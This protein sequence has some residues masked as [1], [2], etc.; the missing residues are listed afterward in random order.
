MNK[1]QNI[2]ALFSQPALQI[3]LIVALLLITGCL[4][5]YLKYSRSQSL[6]STS[7]QPLEKKEI[8]SSTLSDVEEIRTLDQKAWLQRLRG[9]LEKTRNALLDNLQSLFRG[10]G[11]I[12]EE[13]LSKLHETLY[14][15]DI[16]VRTVDRLTDHLKK[17]LKDQ[18]QQ[19]SSWEPI[20]KILSEEMVQILDLPYETET[21][22]PHVI[23]VIG[24][25]GVGKTTTI[26]KLAAHYLAE[27]K[28]VLLCAA[29]TYR[30]AAIDQLEIW[31]KRLGV[32]VIA[33]QEGSDPAAVAY[34][35]VKAAVARDVDVLLIDT[36]G[37]LHNKRHLMDELAK[38]TKVM[39]REIPEAP[40]E[41]YLVL[42]ATTG[43]NAMMQLRSFQEITKITGICLT[44]LDGT[45]KGGVILGLADEYKIP[46][47]YVGVGEKASD[48]RKFQARDFV[49][50]LLS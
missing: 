21:K 33:H 41:T 42:D 49:E 36:A 22:K 9:G 31:G 25:N 10:Q 24:V 20:K 14:R 34:D 11:P 43:Q 46:I 44:K 40:H 5:Y 35:S 27:N 1:E 32:K 47:K 39:K 12:N 19:E 45:A 7:T 30:A 26:G 28:S 6:H 15:S 13:V 38:I 16:S 48:L 4:L 3:S 17:K 37:R 50:S 18:S 23:L 29:D 8:P 2:E